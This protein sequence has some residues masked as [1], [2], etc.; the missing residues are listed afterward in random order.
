MEI[1]RKVFGEL[2]NNVYIVYD[3][4]TLEGYVIDPGYEA[5]KLANEKYGVPMNE[6]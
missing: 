5:R 6:D 2:V 3:E 1:I 4:D